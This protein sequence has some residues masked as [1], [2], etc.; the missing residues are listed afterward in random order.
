MRWIPLPFRTWGKIEKWGY[1]PH[2]LPSPSQNADFT[3][4]GLSWWKT[5]FT[6]MIRIMTPSNYHWLRNLCVPGATLVTCL[7]PSPPRKLWRK[8]VLTLFYI[9]G[10]WS[11]EVTALLCSIMRKL[12]LL[13]IT[14]SSLLFLNIWK[15]NYL[16]GN[17]EKENDLSKY[18]KLHVSLSLFIFKQNHH[19]LH[20][21]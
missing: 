2:L 5:F 7:F 10:N 11:S 16:N 13:L 20:L 12:A 17:K 14:I 1:L 21:I 4:F 9:W 15:T 3:D 18:L 6:M 8:L 19:K